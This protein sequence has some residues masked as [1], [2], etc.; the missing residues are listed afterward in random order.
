MDWLNRLKKCEQKPDGLSKMSS[1]QQPWAG[2]SQCMDLL[3]QYGFNAVAFLSQL[4]LRLSTIFV[5]AE[6]KGIVW[7]IP[8]KDIWWEFI[9]H[10]NNYFESSNIQWA[11]LY[12]WN[13]LLMQKS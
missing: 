8:H 6:I 10:P 1:Y 3:S 13:E 2:V 9:L 7:Y 12:A 5:S 4:S 11:T